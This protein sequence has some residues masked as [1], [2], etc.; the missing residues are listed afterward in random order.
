MD[1]AIIKDYVYLSASMSS[2]QIVE[3]TYEKSKTERTCQFL[4][5]LEQNLMRKN[6]NLKIF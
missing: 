5:V 1:V 6:L 2:N 4:Q 3:K